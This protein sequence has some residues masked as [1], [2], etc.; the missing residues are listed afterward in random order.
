ML[1]SFY[2]NIYYIIVIL[3]TVICFEVRCQFYTSKI[4]KL[5]VIFFIELRK[6]AAQTDKSVEY[7][8]A[9]VLN[10]NLEIANNYMFFELSK[11]Y[12]QIK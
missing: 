11:K 12:R 5:I 6:L 3:Y 2:F 8:V 10:L 1:L 7:K 9:L 4:E